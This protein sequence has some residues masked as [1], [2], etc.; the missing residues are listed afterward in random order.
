VTSWRESKAS[1]IHSLN[2]RPTQ[3]MFSQ[4]SSVKNFGGSGTR[5]ESPASGPRRPRACRAGRRIPCRP[6]RGPAM[7]Q[8]A[9]RRGPRHFRISFALHPDALPG[10]DALAEN[11]PAKIG[12]TSSSFAAAVSAFSLREEQRRGWSCRSALN[13]RVAVVQA[14]MRCS[15][16]CVPRGGDRTNSSAR[17]LPV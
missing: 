1:A 2:C 7:L 15:P 16:M 4:P 12:A 11:R 3:R 8:S 13:G 10:A 17:P 9:P 6:S 5:E 14:A